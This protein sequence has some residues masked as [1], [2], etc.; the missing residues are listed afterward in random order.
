M[1]EN[2]ARGPNNGEFGKVTDISGFQASGAAS[3]EIY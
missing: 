3:K 1:N 2:P